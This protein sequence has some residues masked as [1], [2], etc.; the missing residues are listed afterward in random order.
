M[1]VYLARHGQTVW[2]H[3]DVVS[4]RTDI[5]LTEK[6]LAQAAELAEQ[7]AQTEVDLILTSPLT[8][9]RQTAQV[10]AER[11]GAPVITEPLLLEQDFGD[12]EEVDRFYPEYLEYRKEFFRRFPG[13]GESVAMV[14][15]RAY[16]V[17]EKV[18][19]QYREHTVLLVSHGGFC[20]AFRTWFVD[21]PND[22][23]YRFRLENCQLAEFELE[24][25]SL[26]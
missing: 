21:T 9:A 2:N 1:K 6:G 5:P 15:C 25:S 19:T 23:F 7:V 10:V 13:G 16:Q 4:G 3:R 17:I 11:I 8:R 22:A 18:R 12:Y 24:E 14:A 20:R 26:L